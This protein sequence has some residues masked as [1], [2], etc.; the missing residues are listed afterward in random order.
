MAKRELEVARL[1]AEGLSNKQIAARLFISEPTVATHVGNI[2]D[3]LGFNSGRRSRAGL[4]PESVTFSEVALH[5][6]GPQRTRFTGSMAKA[7]MIAQ[8]PATAYS[9]P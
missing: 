8:S 7:P 2:M 6:P 4:R 5:R 3:K 9:T 1:V